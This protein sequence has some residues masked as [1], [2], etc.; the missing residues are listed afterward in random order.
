MNDFF[1]ADAPYKRDKTKRNGNRVHLRGEEYKNT[2]WQLNTV[3]ET[4]N[5]AR[6]VA[7]VQKREDWAAVGVLSF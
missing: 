4:S 3:D 1:L 7:G 5:K 6:L 2:N